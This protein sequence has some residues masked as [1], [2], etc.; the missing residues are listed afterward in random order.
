MNH[1]YWISPDTYK[2]LSID[3]VLGNRCNFACSYCSS[4]NYDGSL[5]WVDTD[6]II[7]LAAVIRDKMPYK[8]RRI[9]NLL[10]GEP[11]LMPRLDEL[12]RGIKSVDPDAFIILTTNGSRTERFWSEISSYIDRC[13]F[14]VHLAQCDV[15]QIERNMKICVEKGAWVIANVLM[16]KA[17]WS[18]AVSACETYAAQAYAHCIYAKPVNTSIG[19]GI[20]QDYTPEQMDWL[21]NWRAQDSAAKARCLDLLPDVED[22]KEDN[23]GIYEPE[24]DSWPYG[25]RHDHMIAV[26]VNRFRDWQCWIGIDSML[27]DAKGTVK[28]GS[29]CN[30]GKVY[31]NFYQDDPRGWDWTPQPTI[32]QYHS[33]GCGNDLSARKFRNK[34]DSD[35]ALAGLGYQ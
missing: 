4:I 8:R 11:T 3:L 25:G 5:P 14:S 2:S 17:H 20:L 21:L 29:A 27:I 34:T 22:F 26:G 33:C 10:G 31:G 23:Y 7:N 6:K 30:L 9:Y 16:D 24:S 35:H 32:C 18:K 19:S 12:L 13:V 28:G 1:D 15:D